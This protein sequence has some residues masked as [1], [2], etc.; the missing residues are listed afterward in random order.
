[1]SIMTWKLGGTGL[2]LLIA[3]TILTTTVPAQAV[4]A[5]GYSQCPALAR[6]LGMKVSRLKRMAAQRRMQGDHYGERRLLS[7]ANV[8]S[9]HR[10]NL[11]CVNRRT[12][13]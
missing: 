4:A 5:G 9:A 13:G 10:G 6:T 3:T 8:I 2:A 11:P 7:T 1:M 12:C